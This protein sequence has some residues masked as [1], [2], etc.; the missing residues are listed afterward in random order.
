MIHLQ[1]RVPADRVDE[2]VDE[3]SSDDSVANLA[4]VP[5][6][7]VKPAGTLVVCDVAREAA[8][9]VVAR[10]RELRIHHDGSIMLT[11]PETVLSDEATRAEETAPGRPDDGVVWDAVENRVRRESSMSFAYLAFLL[12]AVLLAGAGR[13][14]DQP[15]LIV[16]AMVVGPEFSPIAAICVG[17]ARPRLSIVPLGLRTLVLGYVLAIVLAVPFWWVTHLIGQAESGDVARGPL[18]AFIVQPNGW[19]FVV[20]LMAGIAG[21]LA[22]TTAKSGPLVGGFISVT[23]VPAAGTV[24]LCVGTGVWHEVLPAFLQLV[25]NLTGM[26][27]AGTLTL[28]AQRLYWARKGGPVTHHIHR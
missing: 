15:I 25:V 24:A 28:L 21:T 12:L 22:L 9:A 13:L 2:V 27:V 16:G 5:E 6:A 8:N 11:E 20:A 23:T 1:M 18:T 3:L 10:L 14:L 26:I 17:L 4:V 7:F 19:S